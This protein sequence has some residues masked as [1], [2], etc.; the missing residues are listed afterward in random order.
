MPESASGSGKN[1]AGT[2]T[3]KDLVAPGPPRGRANVA[4]LQL[5]I[6]Y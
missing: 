1:L 6:I 3:W 2:E 4:L 5:S